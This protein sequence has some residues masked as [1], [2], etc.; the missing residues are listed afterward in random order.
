MLVSAEIAIKIVPEEDSWVCHLTFGWKQNLS[1]YTSK[2]LFFLSVSSQ[3]L[4]SAAWFPGSA[5]LHFDLLSVYWTLDACL[6]I[7]ILVCL[8]GLPFLVLDPSLLQPLLLLYSLC[9]RCLYVGLILCWPLT[10]L[11]PVVTY[12]C[13]STFCLHNYLNFLW[14]RFN[15]VLETFLVHIDM[16]A[17]HSS[18]RF[19][20]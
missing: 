17:S 13:K 9:L 14:H 1:F 10:L 20:R 11:A 2:F 7:P 8:V 6:W 5:C 19:I 18:Y 4:P 15:T 16:I 12:N 3:T